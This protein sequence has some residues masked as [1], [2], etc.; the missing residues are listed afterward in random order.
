MNKFLLT[1]GA[2]GVAA[3]LNAQ[4]KADLGHGQATMSEASSLVEKEKGD[5]ALGKLATIHRSDSLY[6]RSLMQRV[7][8]LL[9]QEAYSSVEKLCMEGM[10]E[11]GQLSAAFMVIRVAVLLDMDR[12]AEALAAADSAIAVL[13]GNFRSHHLKTMAYVGLKDTKKALEQAMWN[14]R[15]F[16]YQRDAHMTLGTIAQGE[17]HTAQA[18]LALMMAQLVRFEDATAEKLLTYY[19]GILGGTVAP[20]SE[21]YDMSVTGDE[22][23]D[24]DLLIRSKVAM[25]RKYKVKPDLDYPMCRQSHLLLKSIADKKG[26]LNGFYTAFYGPMAKAIIEQGRFEAFV[27]HCLTASSS[28]EVN[29]IAEKNRSKV[30]EFRTW[31]ATVMQEHYLFFPETEGGPELLHHYND[32]D[33]L[34]GFGTSDRKSG[35][36]TGEWTIYHTNGRVSAVGSF[37]SN[38]ERTGKWM[39]WAFDGTLDS[40]GNYK[41]GEV[42]GAIVNYHRTGCVMDSTNV[43]MGKRQGLGCSFYSLGGRRSCKFA[44]DDA[45]TGAATE[46]FPSGA[47]EW[48]YELVNGNTEGMATQK[49]A[50]GTLRFTGDFKADMR[51]GTFVEYHPNGQKSEE[52]TYVA[53]KSDGPF[54]EWH[55]NGQLML[56]GSMKGGAPIGERRRYDEWGMLRLIDRFGDGGK[57]QGLREEFN[58]DG[59]R[60]L[61]M[62]YT[63]DLLTRYRYYATDGSVLGEGTRSKGKFQ[64]KGYHPHGQLR[65]E[66]TYLD[67]GAKDGVWKYYYADGTLDSEE[68]YAKGKIT[69]VQKYH[70]EDGT[71]S[72]QDETYKREGNDY[73]SFTR[74]YRSGQVREQGQ[75]KGETTEGVVRRF[76]P[77][78]T[79]VSIEY[80]KDGS[81]DGWQEFFDALGKRVYAERYLDGAIAER[82]SCDEEGM[83]YERIVVKPGAFELVTHYPKGGVMARLQMMNGYLHGKATWLYPDGSLEVEGN[84]LNGDRHGKWAYMHPNGKK[85]LEE[86]YNMGKQKG[87][88]RKWFMDGTPENE[89]PYVDGQRHGTGREFHMNGKIAFLREYAYGV[90]HGRLISY[91]HDGVPQMVRFYNKGDLVA[92]GSPAADGSVKDTIALKPGV[93]QLETHFPNGTRARKMTYRNGEIDGEF[94]E[95]HANGQLM[96]E[97]TQRSGEVEGTSTEYHPNGKVHETMPYVDGYLHGERVI[98]WDNG[99]AR[100][101]INYVN[102]ER[103]GVWTV[104]DRTGK[105]VAR[106]RMRNDDVVE[107]GK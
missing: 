101:R 77:D 56:E 59:T 72:R 85:R 88:A 69:G 102:G 95:Y 79:L 13:P 12:D 14:A 55:P 18:A 35:T 23:E 50:D 80:Y 27:Y 66:G 24:L 82:V 78:G 25:D 8:I 36:N 106:Y 65:V 31:L 4:T 43:R 6:E 73:R 39:H 96:E 99:L 83:A 15:H 60:T 10:R 49:F 16:P 47:V 9:D 48:S 7:Q 105:V 63:R 70:R 100:E 52:Y 42:D 61:D 21:G 40:E 76:N 32:S 98:Y 75:M 11:G 87:T 58:A 54:K 2:L 62:E 41:N 53:G 71:L 103:H 30:I 17:G 64:L 94:K 91:T 84:F 28:R 45:W 1:L 29:G 20:E 46:Y 26:K 90:P 51:T 5:E 107:M 93:M 57:L 22:L 97:S 89:F 34:F 3:L 74:Y 92:Y 104:H 33:D 68:I 37:D 19:D 44:K 67:E 81:R 38:G 86:E